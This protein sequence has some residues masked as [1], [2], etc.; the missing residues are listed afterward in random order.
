MNTFIKENLTTI[1]EAA[2]VALSIE[3]YISCPGINIKP[4]LYIANQLDL[5]DEEIQKI[6]VGLEDYLDTEVPPSNLDTPRDLQSKGYAVVVFTPEELDGAP[7]HLVE[8]SL[9]EAGWDIIKAA[10]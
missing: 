9:I 8:D 3:E 2:R 10:K 7:R 6:R 1:L 4:W 5:S